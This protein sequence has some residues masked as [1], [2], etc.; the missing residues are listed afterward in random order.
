MLHL[1]T[2]D[3]CS[4]STRTCDV[5][6]DR[7]THCRLHKFSTLFSKFLSSTVYKDIEVGL[8]YIVRNLKSG[9]ILEV[10]LHVCQY[11]VEIAVM[12]YIDN[13]VVQ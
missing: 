4:H 8:A 1:L 9:L 12:L 5:Q 11:N 7:V 6:V 3:S 2:F 13:D 10:S